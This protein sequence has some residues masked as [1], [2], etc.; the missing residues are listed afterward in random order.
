MTTDASPASSPGG[1]YANQR[2]IE[3]FRCSGPVWV[4]IV[5]ERDVLYREGQSPSFAGVITAGQVQLCR[6]RGGRPVILTLL[7]RGDTVGDVPMLT[8]ALSA[9]DAIAVQETTIL[10]VEPG[11]L[12][13]RLGKKANLAYHW[14]AAATRQA[15]ALH[16]RLTGLLIGDLRVRVAALIVHLS[17]DANYVD[18]TQQTL[19]GMLATERT[20]VNRILR[21]LQAEG[22][23]RVHRG[24][25]LIVDRP[26]LNSMGKGQQT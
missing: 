15:V 26:A 12:Q 13:R 7:G 10:V 16:E 20:S 14:A 18:I 22:I 4:R 8:G 24:Q 11:E 25:L 6:R 23:L 17:G 1:R 5:P 21:H 19:A 2:F 3:A 9:W